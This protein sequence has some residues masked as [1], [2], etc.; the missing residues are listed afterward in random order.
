MSLSIVCKVMYSNVGCP[1]KGADTKLVELTSDED[2]A[3]LYTSK[4]GMELA[5]IANFLVK[6]ATT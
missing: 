4:C 3:N 2:D 1:H 5:K 6:S